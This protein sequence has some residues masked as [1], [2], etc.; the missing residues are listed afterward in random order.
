[1]FTHRAPHSSRPI[2]DDVSTP[3]RTWIGNHDPPAVAGRVIVIKPSPTRAAPTHHSARILKNGEEPRAK[4]PC[5]GRA[6]L[7]VW[8][9][10]PHAPLAGVAYFY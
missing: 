2:R 3:L 1:M 6:R 10:T 4:S 8:R 5:R 9:R 7:R